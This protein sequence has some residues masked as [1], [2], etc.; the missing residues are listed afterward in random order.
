MDNKQWFKEAGFGMMIHFGLYSILAGEWK[1]Q[2]M[3]GIAEWIQAYFK[4]PNAEYH[5]LADVFNPIYF[6]AEEWV[7]LA[8]KAGMKYIVMTSEHHEGF[9]LYKS[10][11]SPFN[12]YDM[13]PCKRD[14]IGEMAEACR[15][16]GIKFGLYYSQELDWSEKHGGGYTAESPT[17]FGE[18]WTNDW[19]F[20]NNEKDYTLCFENKIKLQVEEILTKYGDLCLIWFDT[21]HTISKEQSRELCDMV[22][23][24]Q[25]NCLVNSRVGNGLGDYASSPDNDVNYITDKFALL[26]A[27]VTL[28]NTWGFKYYDN[29]WKDVEAV[30]KMKE[31]LN[32]RGINLLLNIGPDALGRIPAP[33]YKI[34]SEL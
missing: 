14:I 13:S 16:H 4:I 30:K 6:N 25:P 26:E 19:D 20:D 2:R 21:P 31:N 18:S 7:Q 33:A 11:V 32:S 24:Y 29:N 27:P 12:S 15:K 17:M 22:K 9:A 28:N 34:L 3:P 1:G 10:N 8:K 23:K 5:K